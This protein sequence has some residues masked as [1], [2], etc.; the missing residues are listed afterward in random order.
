MFNV[1]YTPTPDLGG[2]GFGNGDW[3]GD[4]VK[5][6]DQNISNGDRPD[7]PAI[8][9]FVWCRTACLQQICFEVIVHAKG[10]TDARYYCDRVVGPM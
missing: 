9:R 5:L 7:L 6:D 1:A 4:D 2:F 8:I 3:F 10:K